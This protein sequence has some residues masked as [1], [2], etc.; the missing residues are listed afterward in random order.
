[1][2]FAFIL[3]DRSADPDHDVHAI[4]RFLESIARVSTRRKILHVQSQTECCFGFIPVRDNQSRIDESHI[5]VG[6][7][8]AVSR[9]KSRVSA[10]R[11]PFASGHTAAE[12]WIA[13][14]CMRDIL[15]MKLT[16][17]AF[18]FSSETVCGPSYHGSDLFFAGTAC[19]YGDTQV[20]PHQ[21]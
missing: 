16:S 11:R 5:P 20:S 7:G 13:T 14:F 17:S 12:P 10:D 19:D 6:T 9:S 15:T 2:I 8:P 18:V 4:G 3:I 1:M 21:N